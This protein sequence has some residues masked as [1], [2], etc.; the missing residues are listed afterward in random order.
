MAAEAIE[1]YLRDAWTVGVQLGTEGE[2]KDTIAERALTLQT[3][4]K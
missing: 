4:I 3:I 2:Q 1:C